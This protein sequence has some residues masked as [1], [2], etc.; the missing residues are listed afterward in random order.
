MFSVVH[1]CKVGCVIWGPP[2][3][4]YTY[5]SADTERIYKKAISSVAESY[6]KKYTIEIQ[7]KVVGRPD[8]DGARVAVSEMKLPITPEQFLQKY[9]LLASD[10]VAKVALM[11]G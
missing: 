3:D 8:L 2:N 9:K 7:A 6:G 4:L 5:L 1:K 11:P 10:S